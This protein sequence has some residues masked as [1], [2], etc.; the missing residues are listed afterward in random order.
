M[1]GWPVWS[2]CQTAVVE[3]GMRCR[4]WVITPP[5]VVPAVAFEVELSLKVFVD[6]FDDL[7]GGL[8]N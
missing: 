5:G 8:K 2:L 1:T 6:R 3:A 4:T 7:H